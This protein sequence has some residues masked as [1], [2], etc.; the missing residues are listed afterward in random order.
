M[1]TGVAAT[2]TA[3]TRMKMLIFDVDRAMAH[4]V[5]R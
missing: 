5:K 1:M 2:A 4:A 3:T